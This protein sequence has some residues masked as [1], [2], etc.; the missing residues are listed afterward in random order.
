MKLAIPAE[1][2]KLED[3]PIWMLRPITR[4][5]PS[6]AVLHGFTVIDQS[7]TH[8]CVR[9]SFTRKDSEE[10]EAVDLTIE[11]PEWVNRRTLR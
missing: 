9:Y 10:I 2:F 3:A 4:D 6:G 8:I 1:G 5:R 7:K 11:I